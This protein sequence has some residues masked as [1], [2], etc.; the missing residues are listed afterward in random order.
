M[1]K[2]S[3]IIPTF[4]CAHYIGDAL[5]SVL[6][7]ENSK[8]HEII[9]VDDGSEDATCDVVRSIPEIL[10]IRQSHQGTASAVNQG[11]RKATGSFLSFLDADDLWM[12]HKTQLQMEAF[13]RDPSLDMIFG[14]VEQF[15]SPELNEFEL[16]QV[17][18]DRRP[19]VGITKS[20]WI[21]KKDALHKVGLFGGRFLLE[22]FVDWYMRAK[23]VGLNELIIPGVVVKRRIHQSNLS[24]LNKELKKDFPKV[25]KAALERR[26]SRT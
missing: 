8:V 11:I 17:A 24:R 2:I 19:M 10:Y 22:E 5:Q 20:T 26:R 25:I 15:A 6:N 3:V 4:N 18:F 13:E 9:V 7:Q 21:I 1:E 12:P 23:E 16:Q 14:W